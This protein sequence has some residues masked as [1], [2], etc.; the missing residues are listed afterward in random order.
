MSDSLSEWELVARVKSFLAR[1]NGSA[2]AE[3]CLAC[4][5]FHNI[6]DPVIRKRIRRMHFAWNVID[7]SQPGRV[8]HFDEA[9]SEISPR[10]RSR[11]RC[12]VGRENCRQCRQEACSAPLE[13]CNWFT[14]LGNGRG[15]AHLRLGPD[16]E[17]AWKQFKDELRRIIESLRVSLVRT[18][19]SHRGNGFLD[20]FSVAEIANELMLTDDCALSVLHRFYPKIREFLPPERFRPSGRDIC[21][22]MEK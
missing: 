15:V 5:E 11:Q 12:R 13:G 17:N 7:D 8:D 21:M 10:C 14:E 1:P 2:T 22:K 6:Y 4:L 18:R 20:D 19:S 3:E 9:A 16:I